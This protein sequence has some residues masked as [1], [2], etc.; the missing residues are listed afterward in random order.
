MRL[1]LSWFLFLCAF[2]PQ[3]SKAAGA[4][5]STAMEAV[6]AIERTG[7]QTFEA[8]AGTGESAYSP[9]VVTEATGLAGLGSLEITNAE[10]SHLWEMP[11]SDFGKGV[12]EL[13][14]ALL[15]YAA[16]SDGNY[17]YESSTSLWGNSNPAVDFAFDDCY[18]QTVAK[19]LFGAGLFPSDF[20][21]QVD[22]GGGVMRKKIVLDANKLV[23]DA[24]HQ[25]IKSILSESD[26]SDRAAAIIL[27]TL[28]NR[29]RF[30]KHFDT[31]E[32]GLYLGR[33]ATYMTKTEPMNHYSQD[34][35]QVFSFGIGAPNQF[36]MYL[37]ILYPEDG[38]LKR[39]A[40]SLAVRGFY[41]NVVK[42]MKYEKLELT[43]PVGKV[44]PGN[45]YKLKSILQALGLKSAFDPEKARFGSLGKTRAFESNLYLEDVFTRTVYE[46]TPFGFEAAAA[47]AIS[48]GALATGLAEEPPKVRIEGPALHVIR[49]KSGVPLFIIEFD[50][51]VTQYSGARILELIEEGF[52][53]QKVLT[54][55]A[56]GGEKIRVVYVNK[57]PVIARIGPDNKTI[58]EKLKDL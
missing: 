42:K 15:D 23:S 9:M 34:G 7:F 4:L 58:I 18:L 8:L 50:K 47:A 32:N 29:G 28:Y 40:Q 19:P 11:P 14:Q 12:S 37:D 43:L 13:R 10:F 1:F 33:P 56:D 36:G 21:A 27:A 41:K 39:L 16:D 17:T 35:L 46:I 51:G 30:Q 48:V 44:E 57:K 31:L 54:F 25:L 52:R 45:T 55:Q 2:F 53:N 49:H 38:D 20:A 26:V 3:I 22:I 5:S 24:T 6:D